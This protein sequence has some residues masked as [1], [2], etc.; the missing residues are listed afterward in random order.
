[1]FSVCDYV[2]VI[3]RLGPFSSHIY[4]Q[5][6]NVCVSLSAC[7]RACECVRQRWHAWF[8]QEVCVFVCVLYACVCMSGCLKH[9]AVS[10]RSMPN[11]LWL[12]PSPVA[13][14]S[15]SLPVGTT[16]PVV[17]EGR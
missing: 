2:G 9:G 17:E 11:P 1:M 4:T 16:Q 10:P 7:A 14:Y 15:G 5:K 12:T 3:A 13:P 8:A 6:G